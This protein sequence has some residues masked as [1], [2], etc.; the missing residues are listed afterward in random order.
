MQFHNTSTQRTRY[1]TNIASGQNGGQGV[2]NKP[3]EEGI[4]S[5]S[6][7]Q[8]R[9]QLGLL[10]GYHQTVDESLKQPFEYT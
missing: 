3:H 7:N 1:N 4:Q 10:P 6:M 8:H 9:N 5:E 2:E